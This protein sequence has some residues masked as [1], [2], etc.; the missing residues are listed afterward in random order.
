MPDARAA[1]IALECERRTAL[2]SIEPHA[3][4][5]WSPSARA[6]RS[7]GRRARGAARSR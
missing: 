5:S 6:T 3:T 4:A 2:L 7:T 1:A